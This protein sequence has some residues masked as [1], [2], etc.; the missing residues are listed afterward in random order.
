[1]SICN[2]I[3]HINQKVETTQMTIRT[4]YKIG[5]SHTMEHYSAM[6]RNEIQMHATT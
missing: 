6:K 2:S 5:F 4:G 1:M 3:I